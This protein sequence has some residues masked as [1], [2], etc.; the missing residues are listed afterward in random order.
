MECGS[1]ANSVQIAAPLLKKREAA[2]YLGV[3]CRT[4]ERLISAGRIPAIKIFSSCRF[5]PEDL[6]RLVVAAKVLN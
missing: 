3:S 2:A 5:D 4:I 1:P 6:R